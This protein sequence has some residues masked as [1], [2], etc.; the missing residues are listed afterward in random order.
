MSSATGNLKLLRGTVR[1][2]TAVKDDLAQTRRLEQG[3]DARQ[4]QRKA[5]SR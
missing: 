3:I 5:L 2:Q 4:G 1:E